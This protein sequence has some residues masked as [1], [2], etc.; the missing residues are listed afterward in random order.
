[1]DHD[2]V[3]VEAQTL[4]VVG[5]GL[6]QAGQHRVG[7]DLLGAG[8]ALGDR[9][10]H[11]VEVGGADGDLPGG[12]DPQVVQDRDHAVQALGERAVAG[13]AHVREPPA[14]QPLPDAH[15]EVDRPARGHLPVV[16]DLDQR[17]GHQAPS[18]P[19]IASLSTLR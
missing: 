6:A 14:P 16:V 1:V 5:A 18:S 19:E 7:D 3:R 13:G 9:A 8:E 10:G 17:A 2:Q 4:R 12:L 11:L 15:E